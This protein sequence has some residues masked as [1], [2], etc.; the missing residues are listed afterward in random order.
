VQSLLHYQVRSLHIGLLRYEKQTFPCLFF[1]GCKMRH[2]IWR[3]ILIITVCRLRQFCAR[4]NMASNKNRTK[5]HRPTA[6]LS[7][8]YVGYARRMILNALCIHTAIN[9]TGSKLYAATSFIAKVRD[10][11]NVFRNRQL[12]RH[13]SDYTKVKLNFY[14]KQYKMAARLNTIDL[15]KS[16]FWLHPMRGQHKLSRA[17]TRWQDEPQL[18]AEIVNCY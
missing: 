1:S 16:T 4:Q 9:N 15:R 3:V 17:N 5:T 13:L 14:R 10:L 7:S 8:V 12:P 11:V 6:F 2:C 18:D